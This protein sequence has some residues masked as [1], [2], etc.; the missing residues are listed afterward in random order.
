MLARIDVDLAL[1]GAGDTTSSFTT[2]LLVVIVDFHDHN[3]PIADVEGTGN[4]TRS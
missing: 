1:L 2:P 4:V 3:G